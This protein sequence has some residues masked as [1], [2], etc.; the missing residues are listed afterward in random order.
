MGFAPGNVVKVVEGTDIA[1]FM[2]DVIGY[3]GYVV[4]VEIF[5]EGHPPAVIVKLIGWEDVIFF[6]DNELELIPKS[7]PT[8]EQVTVEV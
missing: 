5:D 4:A 8:S 6:S 1:D 7:V 3:V 2:P